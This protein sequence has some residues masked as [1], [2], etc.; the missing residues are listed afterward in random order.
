MRA[1]VDPALVDWV[2]ARLEVSALRF[3][4]LPGATSSAVYRVTDS[5]GAAR[6]VLRLFSNAAW[7]AREPDLPQHEAATLRALAD[8]SPLAPRLLGVR[9]APEA[10]PALLMSVCPGRVELRPRAPDP[11]LN[12][13]AAALGAIH[14]TL[15]AG[16]PWRYRS[17][18][19]PGQLAVPAWTAHPA[20]WRQALETH[21]R[22]PPAWQ[23]VFLHRDYHPTN[24]LWCDDRIS[25]VVDWVNACLGPAGIDVAH[26]RLNLALM[27]GVGAA[28]RFLDAYSGV[29]PGYQHDGYWDLEV[30]LGALPDPHEYPPWREFGLAPIGGAELR[31]RLEALLR[32]ALG[33]R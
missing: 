20:L 5:G 7:L 33:L 18:I 17:W 30:V 2:A 16:F 32:D 19:R 27:W 8:T 31:G 10:P 3:V 11:W 6:A 28:T 12:R 29:R 9:T 24:V 21:R 15:I 4:S 13:L 22:G 14:A 1:I 26:C 25:G 23:P